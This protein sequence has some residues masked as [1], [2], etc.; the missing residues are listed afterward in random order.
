[1]TTVRIQDLADP[2]VVWELDPQTHRAVR[3]RGAAPTHGV[4]SRWPRPFSAV[5]A[6][7]GRLWLQV[8]RRRWDVDDIQAVEQLHDGVRE[9]QYRLHLRTGETEDLTVHFPARTRVLRVLDPTHDEIDSWDEDILKVFPYTAADGWTSDPSR[10][11][12]Q[13][14]AEVLPLWS[15]GLPLRGR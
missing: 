12:A 2:R 11:V 14:A 6:H 10:T 13:F 3:G 9:A 15:S 5:F 7:E 1:M 8:G 4:G